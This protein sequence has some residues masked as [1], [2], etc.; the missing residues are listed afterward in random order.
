[1]TVAFA[2]F[3]DNALVTGVADTFTAA[4]ADAGAAAANAA[5]R[6]MGTVQRAI[7]TTSVSSASA[8][9]R[10]KYYPIRAICA[11]GA[12]AAFRSLEAPMQRTLGR[13]RGTARG[14][15]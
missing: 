2:A 1:V 11:H 12:T 15:G 7:F 8:T 6:A 3:A 14:S 4:V 10:P 5:V 13:S 9:A